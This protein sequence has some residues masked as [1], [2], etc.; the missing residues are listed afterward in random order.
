MKTTQEERSLDVVIHPTQIIPIGK[1]LCGY[2]TEHARLTAT[3]NSS[4]SEIVAQTDGN[5]SYQCECEAVLDN[6]TFE[7]EPEEVDEDL[8][9][10]G[11]LCPGEYRVVGDNDKLQDACKIHK[12]QSLETMKYDF[13]V[14][15]PAGALQRLAA[16]NEAGA[17]LACR[18]YCDDATVIATRALKAQICGVVTPPSVMAGPG[19]C[20]IPEVTLRDLNVMGGI[21]EI[22]G[23]N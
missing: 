2:S 9:P 22:R 18:E 19:A 23:A 10:T 20:V 13:S 3:F 1:I 17:H 5:V 7:P 12:S 8:R 4:A 11:L 6:C 15:T 14:R 21:Q 16:G